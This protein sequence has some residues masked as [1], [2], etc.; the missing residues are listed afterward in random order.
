MFGLKLSRTVRTSLRTAVYLAGPRSR[1][2]PAQAQLVRGRDGP[3]K[4]KAPKRLSFEA[5]GGFS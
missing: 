3:E 4:L 5:G 2:N 1:N